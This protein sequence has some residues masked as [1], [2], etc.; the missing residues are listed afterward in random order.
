[1]PPGKRMGIVRW[2]A[3]IAVVLAFVAAVT[4]I[5]WFLK[6]AALG[7]PHLVFYY[8]LPTAIVA[9]FYGSLPAML[10]AILAT[11]C[12]EFFFYDPVY[13]FYVTSALDAG[14][15]VCF[16]GLAVI[17]AKCAADLFQPLLPLAQHN[18][19]AKKIGR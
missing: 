12:A 6:S 11:L 5:L 16:V 15:L 4:A 1:M 8:L 3:P 13:G 19:A 2:T 17:G 10:Y 7:P 14:E 9:T 18:A